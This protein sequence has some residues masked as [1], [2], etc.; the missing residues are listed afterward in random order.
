MEEQ[1]FLI[2]DSEALKAIKIL[3]MYKEQQVEKDSDFIRV[4][5]A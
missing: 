1:V 5:R 2:Q 3:R 4:L